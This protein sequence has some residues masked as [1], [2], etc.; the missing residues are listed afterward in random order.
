MQAVLEGLRG[1]DAHKRPTIRNAGQ[2][3]RDERRTSV[4]DQL[5]HEG[6]TRARSDGRPESDDLLFHLTALAA[7]VLLGALL[8]V[9]A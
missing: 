1:W 6:S 3:A 5:P 7:A 9:L 4:H 2:M 8:A